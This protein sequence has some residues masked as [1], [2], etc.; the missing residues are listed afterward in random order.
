M[1]AERKLFTFS[2]KEIMMRREG[3]H[4]WLLAS[5]MHQTNPFPSSQSEYIEKQ[6]RCL[7]D[8]GW[9][10]NEKGPSE[11]FLLFFLSDLGSSFR[12]TTEAAARAPKK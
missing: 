5:S 6:A 3:S 4:R 12:A 7:T 1:H 9:R 2:R 8:R 10:G 11:N